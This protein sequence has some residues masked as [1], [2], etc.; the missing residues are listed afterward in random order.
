MIIKQDEDLAEFNLYFIG[1][2][3]CEIR[4]RDNFG[5]EHEN[6]RMLTS[7]DHFGEISM[8]YHC[9]RTASVISRNYNTLAYMG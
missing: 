4:V 8:L 2:G 5:R 1:K 7:G 3:D 9:K 6:I